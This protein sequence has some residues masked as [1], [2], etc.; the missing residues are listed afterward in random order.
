IT[1]RKRAEQERESHRVELGRAVRAATLGQL[2][3]LAHEL[4]QPLTAILANAQAARAALGA[5]PVE[6]QGQI[7]SDIVED[8]RRAG[9]VIHRLRSLLQKHAAKLEVVD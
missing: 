3:A 5:A 6:E 2:G 7:L 4:N 9:Q 1:A 8:A